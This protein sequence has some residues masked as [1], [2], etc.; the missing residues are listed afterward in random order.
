MSRVREEAARHGTDEGMLRALVATGPVITSAGMIL[1]GTFSV[2]MVLPI[3]D[4]FEIGFA[5]AFG[6]L[7]DTFLVRSILVPAITWL[8]ATVP[9]GRRPRRR[10]GARR[11]SAASTR[12]ASCSVS[13][14]DA[15]L[16]ARLVHAAIA[17]RRSAP[18][19]RRRG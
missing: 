2:L 17:R 16:D 13:S 11:W 15:M 10:G 1:A 14:A 9:G 19:C 8:S 5:V 7:V 3:W 6:V 18:S 12:R 4:L